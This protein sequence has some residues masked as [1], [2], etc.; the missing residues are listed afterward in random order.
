MEDDRTAIQIVYDT[1]VEYGLF[2]NQV[3]RLIFEYRDICLY[4]LGH[5]DKVL[6][7]LS[8]YR[9]ESTPLL[10]EENN[11]FDQIFD[12]LINA[13]KSEDE[14]SDLM[15]RMCAELLLSMYDQEILKKNPLKK[16]IK[17]K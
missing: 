2:E 4:Q 12:G 1:L 14:T 13:G 11:A 15:S 16:Y 9:N 7:E 10:D 6:K 8:Q 17:K 5:K 3:K